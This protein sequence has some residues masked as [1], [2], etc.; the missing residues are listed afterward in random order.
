MWRGRRSNR[1]GLSF[2]LPGRLIDFTYLSGGDPDPEYEREGKSYRRDIDFAFFAVNFGYS[3]SDY[4]ELTPRERA[5]IYK[6]WEDKL[7][8]DTTFL[9]NAVFTAT[10]NCNRKKG[11]RALKLWKKLKVRK[12]NMEVVQENMSTIMQ[13][14]QKEG[15]DWIAQIYEANGLKPPERKVKNG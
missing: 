4:E 2:F 7:V 8:S 12:A 3:K 10:Y 1:E 9:Y 14:E 6:A 13:I 11:K 15:K 5:F